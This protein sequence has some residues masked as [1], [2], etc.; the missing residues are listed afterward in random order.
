MNPLAYNQDLS[1]GRLAR[2]AMLWSLGFAVL[3]AATLQVVDLDA[4]L[5]ALHQLTLPLIVVVLGLSLVN[6]LLRCLRWH[7]LSRHLD[8]EVPV[9]T[10]SV[11]YVAG[12]AFTIT[13]GKIGEVVRLWFLKRRH[14]YGYAHT[15][16]LLLLDR[17]TDAWPLLL[18]ALLGAAPF[19]G[20]GPAL[21]LITLVLVTG[22][23]I[24][25]HPGWLRRMI[26]L[27]YQRLKRAPRLFAQMLRAARLLGRFASPAL[28]T[29]PLLLGLGGWLAE[30]VG[31]WL[32]LDALGA[33]LSLTTVAFVFG[34]SMLVGSLPI[35]PG[36]IGGAEASMAGLLVWLGVPLPVAV[37][38][39]AVI[40]LAT[41]GFAV[42]VGFL[43][44][45]LAAAISR[46]RAVLVTAVN[47]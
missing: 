3:L 4:A 8:V 2:Q 13:P 27:V 29:P 40:R 41:L 7:Y 45:P 12:F 23:A 10:N 1:L 26:K 20:Q 11:Y 19:A 35:F 44:L 33:S 18:L 6:Y 46:P 32:V 22:S 28:L 38:A 14:G 30:I 42:V 47:P 24:M 17:L 16:G 9:L 21:V 25:L 37:A 36:G 34:F 31:A 15:A 5:V 39:T 43:V